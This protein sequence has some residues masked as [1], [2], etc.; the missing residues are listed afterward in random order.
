MV[1]L[2]FK[3]MPACFT[4]MLVRQP[5][6]T[7]HLHISRALPHNVGSDTTLAGGMGAVGT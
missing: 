4:M 1:E 3:S 2:E 7:D 6:L 5:P